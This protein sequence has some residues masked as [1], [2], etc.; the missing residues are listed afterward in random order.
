MAA[1]TPVLCA[2]LGGGDIATG[3]TA[4]GAGG[5]TFA[6]GS[7]MYLRVKNAN[8][9]ACVVTVTPPAGGND[10]GTTTAPYALT[11]SVAAT[12]GDRIYGPFPVNPFADQNGN[13]NVSYSVTATVSVEALVMST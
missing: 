10:Q 1:L 7:Q 8:A 2:R 6:A 4:A 13:I 3:L 5:D 12:T 11:P 9:A